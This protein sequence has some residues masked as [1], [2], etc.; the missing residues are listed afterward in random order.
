MF[1]NID[2]ASYAD[3]TTPHVSG[4]TYN[5]TVKSLEKAADML[6]TWFS[7]NQIKENEDVM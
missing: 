1:T 6:F 4:E 2:I 7:Y 3:D 5:S